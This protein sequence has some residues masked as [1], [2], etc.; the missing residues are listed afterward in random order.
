MMY[1]STPDIYQ[2]VIETILKLTVIA[3]AVLIAIILIRYLRRCGIIR[4]MRIRIRG[5]ADGIII[6][7]LDPAGLIRACVPPRAEGHYYICGPTG[8]GKTVFLIGLINSFVSA[9]DMYEDVP[10]HILAIDISGDLTDN[11]DIHG[12]I[13]YEPENPDSI[14]Y[15]PFALIDRMADPDAQLRALANIAAAIIPDFAGSKSD[16]GEYYRRG[17][18][19][20]LKACL[21]AF[22]RDKSLSEIAQLITSY[23]Y[24]TVFDLI[25]ESGNAEAMGC[26]SG[27]AGD[28]SAG[29]CYSTCATALRPFAAPE[30]LRT[31][32]RPHPGEPCVDADAIERGSVY[33]KISDQNL[34]Y[35]APILALIV[36]QTLDYLSARRVTADSPEIM[37]VLDEYASLN[38]DIIPSL[39][40]LRKRLCHCVI[41][42]QAVTADIEMI[43]GGRAARRAFFANIRYLV[44]LGASDPE[45]QHYLAQ[46]AGMRRRPDGST[47]WE[48]A[49]EDFGRLHN[50]MICLHAG[51]HSKL[52]K[53]KYY[54][55]R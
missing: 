7:Q 41:A 23:D 32:R 34:E 43:Y 50:T 12:R 18:L 27:F 46:L 20:I 39:R 55:D 3:A 40:K 53:Y 22:W 6:G 1:S 25:R 45:D 49:P 48:I 16:A 19:E 51:G 2:V 11:T 52:F 21:F 17:A 24:Q 38:I 36:G 26:I 4:H 15:D 30:L 10:G 29:G 31:L 44:V 14:P 42:S 9:M 54:R 5:H 13:I 33:L 28:S 8:S 35:Y 47:S 37:L